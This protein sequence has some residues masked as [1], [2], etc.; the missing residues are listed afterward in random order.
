MALMLVVA[1]VVPL[2]LASILLSILSVRVHED[3]ARERFRN[4]FHGFT[5]QLEDRTA[6][7]ER[8]ARILSE[9]STFIAE[10]SLIHR[11]LVPEE[12]DSLVFEPSLRSIAQVLRDHA[13][14]SDL[15]RLVLYDGHGRLVAQHCSMCEASTL[16]VE[17]RRSRPEVVILADDEADMSAG[18][19]TPEGTSPFVRNDLGELA[20]F[21]RA[22]GKGATG[23]VQLEDQRL[24]TEVLFPVVRRFSG[25]DSLIVGYLLAGVQIFLMEE[26]YSGIE[27]EL[28]GGFY[29][30]NYRALESSSIHGGKNGIDPQLADRLDAADPEN[31]SAEAP[32]FL[33]GTDFYY[34]A[35]PKGI[36]RNETTWVHARIKKDLLHRETRNSRMIVATI[37]AISVL[38]VIPIGFYLGDRYFGRPSRELIRGAKALRAGD[39]SARVDLEIDGDLGTLAES[40]NEMAATIESHT[41]ELEARVRER[42]REL[43]E[44]LSA[45]SRFLARVTHEIRNPLNGIMGIAQIMESRNLSEDDREFVEI[46]LTSSEHLLTIVNDILD[47]SKIEAG[48]LELQNRPFSPTKLVTGV[49]RLLQPQISS[50]NVKL[51]LDI[52]N[53]IPPQVIGDPDRLRQVVANLVSNA[54][55]FTDEGEIRINLRGEQDR[56]SAPESELLR[57]HISVADTGVGISRDELNLLFAEYA[58]I[59]RNQSRNSVGTGLGLSIVKELVE[60]MGGSVIVESVPGEGSVFSFHVVVQ[61]A[62]SSVEIAPEPS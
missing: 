35:Y 31:Y 10:V 14:A 5:E 48:R 47:Y 40:F 60:L 32:L 2:I 13:R 28:G 4:L 15:D 51:V 54:S 1:A 12:Y 26:T 42:T 58:Q 38:L 61:Q 22:T 34:S 36:D 43:E 57:L 30:S 21:D 18:T 16:F 49:T 29:G 27:D 11:Y 9:R 8:A 53:D 17:Y 19:T 62:P 56:E 37:F 3:A 50:K 23:R 24:L 20:V 39:Y 59:P 55:K 33:S 44:A 46:I 45:K 25:G 7:T 6:S 52:E 41:G